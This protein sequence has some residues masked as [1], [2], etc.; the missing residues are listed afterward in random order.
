MV[1]SLQFFSSTCRHSVS[2]PDH[3]RICQKDYPNTSI[4]AYL[5][6]HS[7]TTFLLLSL[8]YTISVI[9]PFVSLARAA[10]SLAGKGSTP[11][12]LLR[13]ALGFAVLA[14]I[15]SL[16]AFVGVAFKLFVDQVGNPGLVLQ[17]LGKIGLSEPSK[18]ARTGYCLGG[19]GWLFATSL[20][21]SAPLSSRSNIESELGNPHYRV[22]IC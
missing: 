4:S 17:A 5:A 1:R 2:H 8:A 10:R 20:R 3:P 14:T 13:K 12:Q 21:R 15:I 19:I 7:T 22:R 9:I 11:A 16:Q 18:L 6:Q